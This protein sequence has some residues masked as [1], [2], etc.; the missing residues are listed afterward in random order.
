MKALIVGGSGGIGL[1]LTQ[2]L[3]QR[4]GVE[5]VHAS[6]RTGAQ[7]ELR[8]PRLTWLKLDAS[9]E[10]A[11]AALAEHLPSLDLLVNAAGMLHSATRG[12]EKTVKAIDT[13][14]FLDSM[15]CN[16]LPSLLLA[17][18]LA[19]RLRHGRPAVFAALSARVGSIADNRL[20]G[21]YSYRASKAALNMALKTLALEWRVRLPNC[22]VAALHPGTV[23]TPLSRP[24]QANVPVEKLFTPEYAARCL[25][26]V[27]DR[28]T[29]EQSGRFWSWDGSE[30]PW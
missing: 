22:T 10:A 5:H 28:L 9:D 30:I 26:G 24:F 13:E 18:H 2:Q 14:F 11:V 6:W 12:P 27:I 23:D 4:E 15:R 8:H 19:P 1:A 25:L 21:W 16:V 29:P 3:L 20:G 17:R 7:P